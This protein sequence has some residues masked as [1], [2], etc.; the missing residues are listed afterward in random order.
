M[1]QVKGEVLQRNNLS[2]THE[3][4][5]R[6]ILLRVRGQPSDLLPPWNIFDRQSGEGNFHTDR[7]IVPNNLQPVLILILNLALV[8]KQILSGSTIV[9]DGS[10]L[11]DETEKL[12][13]VIL[14]ARAAT[15]QSIS[16]RPFLFRISV[17]GILHVDWCTP[18]IQQYLCMLARGNKYVLRRKPFCI[19][20]ANTSGSVLN[21]AKYQRLSITCS[22][23]L[24]I[25]I[26]KNG[27]PSSYSIS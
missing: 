21:L 20:T 3:R 15:A 22:L 26:N 23:P 27:E 4:N 10:I 24:E 9:I 12:K 19:L 6:T 18:F 7:T 16:E 2:R 14:V 25:V 5:F 1:W 11:S 17:S 13:H 8:D